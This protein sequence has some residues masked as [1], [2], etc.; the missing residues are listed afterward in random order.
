MRITPFLVVVAFALIFLVPMMQ[1]ENL[2]SERQAQEE[3]VIAIDPEVGQEIKTLHVRFDVHHPEEAPIADIIWMKKAAEVAVDS[4]T[5]YFNIL[6]QE[7]RHR[8]SKK[9]KMDLPVV[10]GIIQ[11]EDDPMKAQYD[12]HEIENLILSNSQ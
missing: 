7:I 1:K 5:P 11:L 3:E 9:F 8:F 4:G 2:V 12:A 10:Q 6:K